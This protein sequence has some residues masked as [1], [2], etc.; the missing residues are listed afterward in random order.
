MHITKEY[1]DTVNMITRRV[2][3]SFPYAD[4]EEAMGEALLCLTVCAD[5]YDP[6]R[7]ASFETF[8]GTAIRNHI[9]DWAV[10]AGRRLGPSMGGDVTVLVSSTVDEPERRLMF[11]EAVQELSSDARE[12]Y[13]MLLRN[14]E[15]LFAANNCNQTR[16]RAQLRRRF[17]DELKRMGVP[18][19]D[20]KSY[21]A[22]NELKALA[23]TL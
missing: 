2:L 9:Y 3:R 21:E 22:M 11:K 13:G 23:A 7:G 18:G 10:K 1:F 12:M 20:R 14:V 15:E 8:L 5:K 17:K 16:I 6:A 19:A 4:P